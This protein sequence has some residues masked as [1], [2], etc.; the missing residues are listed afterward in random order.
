MALR[1]PARCVRYCCRV[2]LARGCSLLT[3]R[4]VKYAQETFD[5]KDAKGTF[6]FVFW[7]Y[8]FIS[9]ANEDN[10]T[11]RDPVRIV[12]KLRSEVTQLRLPSLTARKRKRG[13]DDTGN[14]PSMQRRKGDEPLDSDILSDVAI[15]EAVKR[16]GYTIPPEVAGFKSLLPVRVFFP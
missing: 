2:N 16:A 8:N 12:S 3:S 10:S 11:L 1:V 5:L 6:D 4:Q 14:G 13:D 7:L 15:L 9:L